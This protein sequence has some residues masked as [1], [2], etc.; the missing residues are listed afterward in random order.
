MQEPNDEMIE[1]LRGSKQAALAEAYSN[2][3]DYGRE[4][5]EKKAEWVELT[6]LAKLRDQQRPESNWEYF[7]DQDNGSAWGPGENLHHQ[8]MGGD[9]VYGNPDRKEAA[10]FWEY[11][12]VPE[13]DQFD[14]EFMRG[15]ADG[16]ID[17]FE[18]AK[19]KV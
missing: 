6:R 4:W 16:A 13:E 12:G 3:Q 5:A 18:M 11:L 15:F 14:G 1:R 9:E 17:L 7:F 8:I 2:G 10:E 19:P